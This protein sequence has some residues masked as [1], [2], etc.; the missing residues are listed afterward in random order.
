MQVMG[1]GLRVKY[2]AEYA[3]G[4]VSR[5]VRSGESTQRDFP[6][7][8]QS[9]TVRSQLG[10]QGPCRELRGEVQVWLPEASL[11]EAHSSPLCS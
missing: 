9:T 7:E 3:G 5:V 8:K 1:M 11:Q 4:A 2:R 10:K 6:I